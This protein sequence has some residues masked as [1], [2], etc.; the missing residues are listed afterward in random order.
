MTSKS[1]CD[2]VAEPEGLLENRSIGLHGL[3]VE[4]ERELLAQV[5]PL[6]V[7]HKRDEMGI[8]EGHF[9][10]A[11]L[12]VRLQPLGE[13]VG[14]PFEVRAVDEDPVVPLVDV[15]LEAD[16]Q[17]HETLG[18][19]LDRGPDLGRQVV[20]RQTQVAQGEF[21]VTGPFP[22][23]TLGLLG[24]RVL[25]DRGVEVVSED[26]LDREVAQLFFAGLGRG[27]HV[28]VGVH[29]S[30]EDKAGECPSHD[31]GHAIQGHQGVLEGAGLLGGDRL[32]DDLSRLVQGPGHPTF[33]GGDINGREAKI[34][35]T[36]GPRR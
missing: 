9:E 5:T 6:G 33:N 16:P 26:D 24:G 36:H 18:L 25:L 1:L 13:T 20:T 19:L 2:L 22:F 7:L 14:Q 32:V 29:I 8:G 15:A 17:F 23:E 31:V 11:G 27:A 35:F 4:L 28:L 12:L 21:E 30:H 34:Q 3:G 10:L